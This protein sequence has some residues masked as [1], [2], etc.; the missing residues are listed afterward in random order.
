MGRAGMGKAFGLGLRWRQ[1]LR[2]PINNPT[3]YISDTRRRPRLKRLRL[4][5]TGR[6]GSKETALV[7]LPQIL[8]LTGKI[9]GELLKRTELLT[10][11]LWAARITVLKLPYSNLSLTKRRQLLTTQNKTATFQLLNMLN[12]A[13]NKRFKK[14]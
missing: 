2:H 14:K 9:K 7:W 8:Q 11:W 4:H 5:G 12:L 3:K 6:R 13:L 10:S 1:A